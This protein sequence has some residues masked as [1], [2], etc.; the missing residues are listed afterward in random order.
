[1]AK[2]RKKSTRFTTII[3]IVAVIV[4]IARY[5][6]S[7]NASK[8]ESITGPATNSANGIP[9]AAALS[10][11]KTAPGLETHLIHYR[12]FDVNFNP[13]EHIPNWVAWELTAT[14]AQGTVK[15]SDN[16]VADTRVKGSATPEDYKY[17]PWDRG[18]MAPA[19]DMKWDKQA[20]AESFYMT[21][22]APQFPDLNRGSWNKLEQKCREWAI[23]DSVIYIVCGPIPG[24][25]PLAHIG[26][27]SV[28]VPARFFKVIISPY[29]N[30]PRGIGFIFNNGE[31]PGGMQQCAVSIDSVEAVTGHDF[32]PALPDDIE[33]EIEAQCNFNQWSRVKINKK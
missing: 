5:V 10:N 30:P 31:N 1:M 16:F 14:E 6:D 18:H 23:A 32:F 12:G 4:I 11:V 29:A 26:P 28:T 13:S 33:N 27:S 17:A 7:C 20:M 8:F 19:G 15:R 3:A 9:S 24:E 22:M 2:R 21:N 25:T